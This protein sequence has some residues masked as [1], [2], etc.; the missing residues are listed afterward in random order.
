[1]GS[2][3]LKVFLPEQIE[4]WRIDFIQNIGPT[5]HI[6][7]LGLFPADDAALKVKLL[8]CLYGIDVSTK[9]DFF[10][11][12]DSLVIP[13]LLKKSKT[14]FSNEVFAKRASVRTFFMGLLTL[15]RKSE[16][17]IRELLLSDIQFSASG[18]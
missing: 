11:R 7:T 12:A 17:L 16:V 8:F 10:L 9:S 14:S 15:K 13:Y 3:G 4:I 1:M 6:Y 18:L 5:C 2:Y